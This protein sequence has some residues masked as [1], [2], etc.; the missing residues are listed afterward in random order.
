MRVAGEGEPGENGGP[1]GDLYVTVYIK[2]DEYF[3]RE[4]DNL[5]CEIEIPYTT[6]CLGGQV[7]VKT[8]EGTAILKIPKGTK[9]G[10]ILRLNSLGLPNFEDPTKRGALLVRVQ[11]AVPDKLSPKEEEILL[12]LDKIYKEKSNKQESF[13]KRLKDWFTK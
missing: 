8:L 11:I 13:F 4:G 10:T 6:A 1:H 3:V 5:I 9:A 12:E 7:Q 2:E